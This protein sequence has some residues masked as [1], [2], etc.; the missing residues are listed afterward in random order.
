MITPLN[1]RSRTCLEVLIEVEVSASFCLDF[2]LC[3]GILVLLLGAGHNTGL[4]VVTNT[5]LEEVGLASKRDVL[6]EVERVGGLVVLLVAE[7][8]KKAIGNEF[9]VLLHEVG[10]HAKKSTGKSLG[11]EFLLDFD[12][13]GDDVLN[14]LLAGSVLQVGEQKACKV[15]VETLVT[16]D[17][18]VGEGESSHQPTL[19]QPEDGGERTAEEDTL[20]RGK[21][22]QALGEGG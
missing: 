10:V 4:L 2:S 20:N 16:G 7:G 1:P 9:D 15:G 12:G 14:G 13:L 11:Q 8:E 17:E 18:L 3:G 6:H 21:C 5:L 19:L 22:N